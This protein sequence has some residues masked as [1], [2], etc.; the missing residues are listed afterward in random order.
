ME[1]VMNLR[2][3][4]LCIDC[5]EVFTTEGLACN[6]R[7]PRC[8][9]SVFAPLAGWVQTWTAYDKSS[10]TNS[11]SHYGASTKKQRMEIVHPAPIAA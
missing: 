11:L 8:G 2:D 9:S 7:C 1:E 6:P 4:L 3:A 5:D 10:E